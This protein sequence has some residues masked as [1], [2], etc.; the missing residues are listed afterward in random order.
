[1]YPCCKLHRKILRDSFVAYVLVLLCTIC[2]QGTGIAQAQ[3][4]YASPGVSSDTF[5]REIA[6]GSFPA[7]TALPTFPLGIKA[8]SVVTKE[9]ETVTPAGG[10]TKAAFVPGVPSQPTQ[11]VSTAQFL[12]SAIV[13]PLSSSAIGNGVAIQSQIPAE[14]MSTASPISQEAKAIGWRDRFRLDRSQPNF[15]IGYEAIGLRRGSDSIGPYSEGSE[16]PR[17]EQEIAGR[18][19]FSKLLGSLERIEFKFTGPLHWDRESSATG[20]VD[21]IL[22]ISLN[23]AFNGADRHQQS[24]RIRLS[25][26]E[27]NRCWTGDELSKIFGGL[28]FLDHDEQYQLESTKGMTS[29]NFRLKTHNFM[30]GGQ[31]GLSMFRPLSQRLTAGFGTAMGLYGN[32]TS[33][34][35]NAADGS[36]TLANT[37]ESK[38]RIN[39]LFEWGGRLNYRVSQNIDAACGY[40]WWYFPSLSTAADQRLSD[41]PQGPQ[42]SLRTGDDQLFRG[43]TAGLSM[44]F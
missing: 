8:T 15:L 23:A 35:L 29:S 37:T 17:F 28:R 10:A 36:T 12:S 32:F 42:F 6:P 34:S 9:P 30:V 24:H 33:G 22:P 40:E 38:L 14:A 11:A 21:S 3:I 43:W 26:Y 39:S 18:Y 44:R 41:S 13:S 4:G 16:L 20:P 2:T 7:E 25:S 5:L 31:V 1:M 19:T 27:L